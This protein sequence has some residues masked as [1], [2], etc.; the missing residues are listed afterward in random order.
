MNDCDDCERLPL[1]EYTIEDL[2]K[3]LDVR[4]YSL[5]EEHII[6]MEEIT[7]EWRDNHG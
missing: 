4:V 3:Q 7:R 1:N 6:V 5:W 2:V